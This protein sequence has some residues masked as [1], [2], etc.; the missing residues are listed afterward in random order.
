MKLKQPTWFV[1]AFDLGFNSLVHFFSA[2]PSIDRKGGGAGPIRYFFLQLTHNRVARITDER[3][4]GRGVT[5]YLYATPDGEV[6]WEDYE[7]VVQPLGIPLEEVFRQGG[8]V[9]RRRDSRQVL[10]SSGGGSAA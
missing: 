1:A 6:D 8:L 9:W 3:S 7:Q 4:A 5:L 10:A 2:R